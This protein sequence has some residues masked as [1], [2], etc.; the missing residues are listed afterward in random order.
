M[1]L[2]RLFACSQGS[3][4]VSPI[5]QC[6][7]SCNS[8]CYRL[9][10][11]AETPHTLFQP[12]QPLFLSSYISQRVAVRSRIMFVVRGETSGDAIAQNGSFEV[13]FVPQEIAR[14]VPRLRAGTFSRND[15]MHERARVLP[16]LGRPAKQ[17][18]ILAYI[19]SRR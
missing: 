2:Q 8:R 14:H 10:R 16:S 13:S 15:A 7:Y 19:H 18:R 17:I 6:V 1:I 5:L 3:L 11:T 9:Q 4:R 12:L